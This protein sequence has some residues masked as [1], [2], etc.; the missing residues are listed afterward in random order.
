LLAAGFSI[1]DSVLTRSIEQAWDPLTVGRLVLQTLAL[2][3]A[4]ALTSQEHLKTRISS[5][6]LLLFY[7]V[8]F[9]QEA[10]RLR[11]WA[12]AQEPRDFLLFGI[13]VAISVLTLIAYSLECQ[14][15]G[16]KDGAIHL[17]MP[18]KESPLAT[19]NVYSR[20]IFEWITP[21]MK[22]GARKFITE[23]DLD[24][25]LSRD[26]SAELG[27]KLDSAMKKQL[28]SITRLAEYAL[29]IPPARNHCGL[30]SRVPMAVR[31]LSLPF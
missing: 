30:P 20:W 29:T 7:P 6:I 19:A 18:E 4:A 3:L 23:D 17:G 10:I 25:L 31:T 22:L 8:Y 13:R 15:P 12:I 27:R 9:L 2:L 14:S 11:S 1:A 28:V 5:T 16:L 24:G 21:L 26:A